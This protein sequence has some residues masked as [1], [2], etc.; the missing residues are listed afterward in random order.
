MKITLD[1]IQVFKDLVWGHF[2]HNQREMPWRVPESSG[3]FDPYKI[4]VSEMMLQQT[5]V[6]RVIPKYTQFVDQFKTVEMLAESPLSEVIIAWSGLGYNRRAKFLWESARILREHNNGLIPQTIDELQALPGI[7]YNT[8]AAIMAYAHNQ[9]VVF[10][11]TNIRTVYIHHFFTNEDTV[12]DK[13]IVELVTQTLDQESPREWYWALMD[14][15]THLKKTKGNSSRQ[16]AHFVKQSTF[17]GSRREIRG[18]ILKELQAGPLKY[19]ELEEK[20][21]DE[22]LSAILGDLVSES[23]II[24]TGVMY[25]L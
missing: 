22:R 23:M 20:I 7:G 1:N 14:Y 15:G 21:G 9:P 4:V 16:S 5:Q 8:A 18:S 19:I 11:E 13:D 3:N 24:K 17:K 10:V 25:S 12:Q 6:P 2:A